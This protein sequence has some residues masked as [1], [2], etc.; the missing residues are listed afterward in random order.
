LPTTIR[1]SALLELDALELVEG[2]ADAPEVL[3]EA[4]LSSA[5][6]CAHTANMAT[7]EQAPAALRRIK[8]DMEALR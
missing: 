5:W 7:M 1:V 6:P 4:G 8:R 3:P 2:E